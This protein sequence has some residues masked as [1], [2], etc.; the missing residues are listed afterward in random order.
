MI[1]DDLMKIKPFLM[2][3]ERVKPTIVNK[4]IKLKRRNKQ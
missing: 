1:V 2:K 3:F 4:I